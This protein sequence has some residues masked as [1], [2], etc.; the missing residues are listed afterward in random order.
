RLWLRL[1][2]VRTDAILV[3]QWDLVVAV[4]EALVAEESLSAKGIEAVIAAAIQA[5]MAGTRRRLT[6]TEA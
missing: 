4:A 2:E 6:R 3:R 1:L 5:S